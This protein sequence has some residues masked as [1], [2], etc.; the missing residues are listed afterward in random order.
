MPTLIKTEIKKAERPFTR[1]TVL[2]GRK[3]E[4]RIMAPSKEA[5]RSLGFRTRRK[6]FAPIA[7]N[8]PSKEK[9]FAQEKA[10]LLR[11]LAE[12]PTPIRNDYLIK[13]TPIDFIKDKQKLG[14]RKFKI[15]CARCGDPIAV[16]WATDSTLRD[17]CDLHYLQEHDK[18]TWY[19]CMTV[20]VSQIDEQLG[21][22]CACG[23]DTREYRTRNSMSPILR[24]LATEYSM[25]HRAFN[26][27]TSAFIAI[28]E[29]KT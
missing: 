19:G 4:L 1:I 12:M 27:S 3:V 6:I 29:T 17:W 16:V 24:E 28:R 20:N 13:N 22:E 11:K 8:P 23:E 14:Y 9:N 2:N 25:K 10:V 7:I 15:T 18:N 5:I 21:F 26:K